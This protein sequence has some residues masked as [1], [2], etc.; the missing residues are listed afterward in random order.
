VQTGGDE[1]KGV[2]LLQRVRVVCLL[3]CLVEKTLNFTFYQLIQ[4][5]HKNLPLLL[6]SSIF[7]RVHAS[8]H[9]TSH[10]IKIKFLPS[11]KTC[12]T[13]SSLKG[14]GDSKKFK[15]YIVDFEFK[16]RYTFFIKVWNRWNFI[17]SPELI[18]YAFHRMR[19]FRI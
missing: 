4:S 9:M 6:F 5:W 1:A 11:F 16:S 17:S 12:S 18:K 13:L 7:N 19:F 10:S 3:S 8:N 15:I 14:V 2:V